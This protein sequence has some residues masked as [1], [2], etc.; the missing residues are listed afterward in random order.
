MYGTD[1]AKS[2]PERA[3]HAETA[4]EQRAG[5]LGVSWGRQVRHAGVPVVQMQPGFCESQCEC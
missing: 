5:L 3:A 2:Q 4:S 1:Q